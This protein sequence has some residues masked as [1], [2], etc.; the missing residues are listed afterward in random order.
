A[1]Q[2]A[3]PRN[4]VLALQDLHHYRPGDHE[5]DQIAEKRTS[6]MHRVEAFGLPLRQMAH[7]RRHDVQAGLLEPR[8]DL[9][10]GVFRHRIRFDDG[11]GS[12]YSHARSPVGILEATQETRLTFYFIRLLLE[13]RARTKDS[14]GVRLPSPETIR[15]GENSQRSVSLASGF[16]KPD[17]R[18]VSS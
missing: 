12:L 3:V 9:S 5:S 2:L 7:A 15:A 8:V 4:G 1:H 18:T 16:C 14:S 11:Q 6:T 13:C 10:E 17:P